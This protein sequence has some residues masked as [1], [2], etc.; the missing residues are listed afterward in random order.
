MLARAIMAGASGASPLFHDSELGTARR[1]PTRIPWRRGD[2]TPDVI[3]LHN[4]E[5]H[6]L[7]TDHVQPDASQPGCT[8]LTPEECTMVCVEV[9]HTS[10]KY[11]DESMT[12]AILQHKEWF[13]RLVQEGWTVHHF[14]V[15]VTTSGLVTCTTA[16]ALRACGVPTT[17][18]DN[19]VRKIL[20]HA[21][22]CTCR[23]KATR[24][25]LTS[26]LQPP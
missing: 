3:F 23:F 9:E 24:Q 26:Q 15:V 14:P 2:S 4:S 12:K 1:L 6:R 11:L 20:N 18:A 7:F 16:A 21:L 5:P 10:D 17:A 22:F 8:Q 13:D 19:T 25:K